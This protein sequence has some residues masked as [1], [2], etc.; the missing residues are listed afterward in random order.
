MSKF[1]KRSQLQKI[2]F[3]RVIH[4]YFEENLGYTQI[5]HLVPI[6]R[7][8]IL[9]WVHRYLD[10][11]L[12]EVIE[13]KAKKKKK[14][15]EH[16]GYRRYYYSDVASG[17][18]SGGAPEKSSVDLERRVQ[19]LEKQLFRQTVLTDALNELINVAEEN[20]RIQIRKKAGT[21]R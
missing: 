17:G 19:E 2:Y 3:D 6:G 21:K 18:A 14:Q 4:L 12:D 11:G 8:T 7:T 20:F 16:R 15:E 1:V 9:E 10:S 5:S 13:M